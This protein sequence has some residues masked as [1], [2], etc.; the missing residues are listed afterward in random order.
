M[1][2]RH[3]LQVLTCVAIMLMWCDARNHFTDKSCT[4]TIKFKTNETYRKLVECPYYVRKCKKN[5]FGQRVCTTER[6]IGLC[7]KTF[8]RSAYKLKEMS[9][10]CPGYTETAN[11]NCSRV[12]DNDKY[13][14]Q[15]QYHCSCPDNASPSCDVN[16]GRCT[17]FPGWKGSGCDIVCPSGTFGLNCKEM[18]TCADNESCN[19]A[20]GSCITVVQRSKAT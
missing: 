15:C 16:D 6:R 18:C 10:C 5:W 8:T 12:C 17:C 3:L 11:N 13:G 20:D 7:L 9:V 4:K 14:F 1:D 19:P 2:L